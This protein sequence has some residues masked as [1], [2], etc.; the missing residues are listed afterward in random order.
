MVFLVL[1]R[2]NSAYT[3]ELEEAKSL[4]VPPLSYT[5]ASDNAAQLFTTIFKKG[6]GA[7]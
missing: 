1:V 5:R 6:A 4:S 7:G 3:T 2:A